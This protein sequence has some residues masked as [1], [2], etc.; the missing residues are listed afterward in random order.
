MSKIRAI[1]RI[2]RF[3]GKKER[4]GATV[5]LILMCACAFIEIGSVSFIMILVTLL[6][7]KESAA[8][9]KWYGL[10][11][12]LVG[13]K[14][15]LPLI[16]LIIAGIVLVYIAK[17]VLN[18]LLNY[19]QYKF[20]FVNQNRTQQKYLHSYFSKS[21]EYFAQNS[22]AKILR[23]VSTDIP[24]MYAMLNTFFSLCT[25]LIVCLFLLIY[26]LYV[27]WLAT[28]IIIF[29]VLM[30]SLAIYLFFRNKLIV[31][32]EGYKEGLE[33]LNKW[34]MQGIDNIK[35]IKAMKRERFI[36]QKSERYGH[37]YA[38][39]TRKRLFY[40]AAPKPIIE[41]TI[42]VLLMLVLAAYI[43]ID[44]SGFLSLIPLI[45][46]LLVASI[47]L[48]PSASRINSYINDMNY[49][50]PFLD[51][52]NE[53]ILEKPDGLPADD[54]VVLK[55]K[56]EV[57][58]FHNIKYQNLFFR[59]NETE[60]WIFNDAAFEIKKGDTVGIVG[61]SG[62]G[63]TT[64]V[65]ILIGLLT[66]DSGNM[67]IDDKI[68]DHD[69]MLGSVGYI[70]QKVELIDGTIRENIAF[71]IP[72]DEMDEEKINKL[73]KDVR[74]EEFVMELPDGLDTKVGERGSRLSG[75]QCQRIGIA[76]ALYAN[77]S[78]LVFDEATSALDNDT[79]YHIIESIN[80]MKGK[81]TMIIIAHRLETIKNC[82]YVYEVRD[83]KIVLQ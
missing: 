8:E 40:T 57:V 42:V 33:K 23:I 15:D 19:L 58:D 81:I 39:S 10:V 80:S 46:A 63:K 18:L 73:I 49:M 35:E 47:R 78:L 62:G 31:A 79:E 59:Y 13:T 56:R 64:F 34:I 52:M 50:L 20:I 4:V 43:Y 41:G 12:K 68:V 36:L 82:D 11:A 70:P 6:T 37:Q 74:L 60:K 5:L 22:T 61:E 7:D 54:H 55:D 30:L 32:G 66:P 29:A 21:Y 38:E 44:Q 1:Q 9:T 53:T 45:T 2:L 76:R 69:Y 51:S 24:Y 28:V 17:T 67:Y 83:G 65:D 72:V 48:L 14:D 16:F 75:G 27:S 3:L 25:E 26:L 71:G 77:A